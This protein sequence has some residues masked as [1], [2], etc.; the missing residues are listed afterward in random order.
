MTWNWHAWSVHTSLPFPFSFLLLPTMLQEEHP[1]A[2]PPSLPQPNKIW[3]HPSFFQWSLFLLEMG[4]RACFHLPGLLQLIRGQESPWPSPPPHTLSQLKKISEWLCQ[5]TTVFFLLRWL[6]EPSPASPSCLDAKA[7][8]NSS[9]PPSWSLH[10]SCLIWIML[11]SPA[12]KFFTPWKQQASTT[13]ADSSLHAWGWVPGHALDSNVF[14]SPPCAQLE[15]SQV[16]KKHIFVTQ[17][18]VTW[19]KCPSLRKYMCFLLPF[20]ASSQPP[21]KTGQTDNV[22]SPSSL[23]DLHCSMEI[24]TQT[25]SGLIIIVFASKTNLHYLP[26]RVISGSLLY[27]IHFLVS[28]LVQFPA[29]KV[30]TEQSKYSTLWV[31]S[32]RIHDT[33]SPTSLRVV[34]LVLSYTQR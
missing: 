4:K 21:H 24:R 25:S 31:T 34:M 33:H 18:W 32:R 16:S 23:R 6:R 27:S 14:P 2:P 1:W 26:H 9:L 3:E 7:N 19:F 30:R 22:T 12:P 20:T 8:I 11:P 13:Q 28:Y 15:C 17:I 10:P 5:I 29:Q